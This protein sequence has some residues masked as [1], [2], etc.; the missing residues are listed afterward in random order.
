MKRHAPAFFI[1][2]SFKGRTRDFD[3]RND[4]S[5]PSAIANINKKGS[6]IMI[7]MMQ[8]Y[9]IFETKIWPQIEPFADKKK[10]VCGFERNRIFQSSGVD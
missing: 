2:A 1:V 3:S 9:K 4:G 10:D 8:N 7:D 6:M 5:I